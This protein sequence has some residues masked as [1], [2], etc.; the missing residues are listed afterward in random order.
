MIFSLFNKEIITII[1]WRSR[2]RNSVRLMGLFLMC[3]FCSGVILAVDTGVKS[4]T[5]RSE[6]KF[7]I[8]SRLWGPDQKQIESARI[9]MAQGKE[10]ARVFSGGNYRFIDFEVEERTSLSKESLPPTHL[11][12]YI[13]DYDE[14]RMYVARGPISGKGRIEISQSE[15]Q[16]DVGVSQQE[17]LA[18]KKI[19]E[20]NPT[21]AAEIKS[22][23][24]ELYDAMPGV[25]FVDGERLVNIGIRGSSWNKVVGVSFRDKNFREYDGDV[26][27]GQTNRL[28][29]CGNPAQGGS[30]DDGTGMA[31]MSFEMEGEN[32]WEMTVVRPAMSS[33]RFGEQSGLEIRDVKYRGKLVLKRGHAPVLNVKYWPGGCGAFRDWQD[34]EHQFMAEP[35]GS[36]ET[37]PGYR[38]LADGEVATT[39]VETGSDLGNFRGVAAYQQDSGFGPE[40]VLVTEMSAGWYRYIM[41]WRFAEDGTIRPRYGFGSASSGCV[42][43]A[44]DHHVYWRFDFDIVGSNNDVYKVERGRRFLTAIEDES[45]LFR[46]YQTNLSLLVQNANGDEAYQLTPNITDE[47]AY[48]TDSTGLQTYGSG[49]LWIMQFKGTAGS[50]AELDD[51]NTGSAINIDPWINGESIGGNDVV[52]WYGAHQFRDDASSLTNHDRSGLVLGGVHTVGPDLRPV[53]W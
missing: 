15:D 43:A 6:K 36:T 31:V 13:Y 50:P 28:G 35:N 10:I 47:E 11:L 34:A 16:P 52:V 27:P 7:S 19:V 29:S 49:D 2:M 21:F 22:G 37:V 38:I 44:R 42:C 33:G 39:M 14:G 48:T 41:E 4:K 32:V 25:T 51:P 1:D 12:G 5:K 30:N 20:T 24:I 46:K 17:L 45:K 26:P 9:R 23:E 3:A 40:V 8:K 53:R 18:A